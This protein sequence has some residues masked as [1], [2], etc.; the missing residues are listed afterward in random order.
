M[1][2]RLT[3]SRTILFTLLSTFFLSSCCEDSCTGP[4][5]GI[6]DKIIPIEQAVEMYDEYTDKRTRIIEP[7]LRDLY[8]DPKFRDTR[9]VWFSMEELREYM[10]YLCE[11]EEEN[12]AKTIS[13]VR[14][15]FAAYPNQ[16]H[17]QNDSIVEYPKRQSV[18][19]MP[20]IWRNLDDAH[21]HRKHQ[22]FVID[23]EDENRP[24]RG[25][26]VIV[27]DIAG[28]VRSWNN[29]KSIAH[30]NPGLTSTIMNR[31]GLWP[32]PYSSTYFD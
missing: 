20:T 29:G 31:A 1:K 14:I 7:V 21:E 6:P 2:T 17:F 25:D 3:P 11:I 10:A 28:D 15:Y 5:T 12:P 18:F 26:F 19:M 24:L 22:P 23:P 4:Y 9:S 27:D 13:G 16:T 30:P 32:P 8:G